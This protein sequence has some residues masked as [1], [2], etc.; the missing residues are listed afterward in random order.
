MT[1]LHSFTSFRLRPLLHEPLDVPG[2]TEGNGGTAIPSWTAAATLMKDLG[3]LV[4]NRS[5]FIIWDI[6]PGLLLTEYDDGVGFT[7]FVIIGKNW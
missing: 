6:T 2:R 3:K 1:L 4:E 5:S 7:N